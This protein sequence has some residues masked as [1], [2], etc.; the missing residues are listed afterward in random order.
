MKNYFKKILKKLIC[1]LTGAIFSI[2]LMFLAWFYFGF[3]LSHYDHVKISDKI[4][5]KIDIN[6]NLCGSNNWIT[7][8]VVKGKRYYYDDVRGCAPNKKDNCAF[9]V[10]DLKLNPRYLEEDLFIDDRTF[11]FVNKLENGVAGYYDDFAIFENMPTVKSLLLSSN[12]KIEAFAVS[13][14]KDLKSDI[15]YV[16][17][18]SSTKKNNNVCGKQVMTEMTESLS[19]FTAKNL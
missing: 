6:L 3:G 11:A 1:P 17:V 10:K 12:K 8:L 14:T 9:S 4:Q 16:F 19:I 2:W 15:I 18:M 13:V 5:K 7:T